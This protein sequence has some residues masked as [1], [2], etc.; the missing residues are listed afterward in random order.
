MAT[1][2]RMSV[3]DFLA[4]EET[5]PYLEL[6]NGEVVQKMAPTVRHSDLVV[7]CVVL[8]SSYLERTREGRVM[9]EVR[10]LSSAE[11]RVYLPDVAVTLKGRFP[12][13]PKQ[14]L[15]AP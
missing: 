10:H 7:R 9:T 12:R 11:G 14:L 5:K 15:A 1:K 3:E 8:L 4:L 2:T 6:V 13:D